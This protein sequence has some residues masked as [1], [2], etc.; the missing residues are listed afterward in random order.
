MVKE[1]K[2][3][4]FKCEICGI[5]SPSKASAE[6]CESRPISQDKGVKVG[7]IILIT[8]GEGAG[9]KGKVEEVFI[10]DKDWGHVAWERYWHTVGVQ[11]KIIDG[12]GSRQLKF[13]DYEVVT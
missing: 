10:Y 9:K 13:D 6:L 3:S 11:A 2:I 1:I 4:K 7:D 8:T 5:V 12:F